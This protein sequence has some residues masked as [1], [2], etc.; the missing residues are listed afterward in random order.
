MNK[1]Y[2]LLFLLILASCHP[3]VSKEDIS[4]INGYWEIEKVVLPDGNEKEYPINETFD[5]FQV[6]G[7]KGFRKKVTPQLNGT[8]LVDNQSEKIEISFQNDKTYINY[9]T[10]YTKWKEELQSLSDEK[11]VIVNIAKAE[12]HYKKT[13][14]INLLQDGKKTK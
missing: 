9:T 3:K 8:F 10:P 1:I 11:M 7:D 4:K 14:P 5:Y 2:T 6:K 13:G 12:Y